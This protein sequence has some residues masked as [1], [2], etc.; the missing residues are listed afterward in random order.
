MMRRRLSAFVLSSLL[1]IV[2]GTAQAQTYP[3]RPIRAIVPF[4]PGGFADVTARIVAQKLGDLLGQQVVIENRT[5]ASGTLGVDAAAKS[6]PDGYTILLT[7]GDFITTP[8]LM[9]PLSFDPHKELIPVTM[10][11]TAPLIL[12]SNA[13]A[14]I[15]I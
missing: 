14:G 1:L 6:T 3:T 5:G 10:M 9:P 2:A 13:N 8:S 4:P 12:A 11:A 7:T 15:T